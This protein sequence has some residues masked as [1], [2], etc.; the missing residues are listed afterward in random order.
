[1]VS[2]PSPTGYVVD[3]VSGTSTG[4]TWWKEVGSLYT[5]GY[6][7]HPRPPLTRSQ[8]A[9]LKPEHYRHWYLDLQCEEG[10]VGGTNA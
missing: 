3:G 2:P 10:S 1:M 6:I 4:E 9:A 5:A 7:R 8:P